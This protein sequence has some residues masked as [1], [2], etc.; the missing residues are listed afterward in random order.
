LQVAAVIGVDNVDMAIADA[1]VNAELNG[2]SNATFV[3]DTA[4]NAMEGLLKVSLLDMGCSTH[5]IQSN[6][7][8]CCS[9]I[10]VGPPGCVRMDCDGNWNPR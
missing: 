10:K 2:I 4:E 9:L 6:C 7:N 8:N 5:T 3:A 1:R